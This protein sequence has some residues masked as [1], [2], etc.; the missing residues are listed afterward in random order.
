[1]PRRVSRR[2]Y[3]CDYDRATYL[4]RDGA[5]KLRDHAGKFD[6]TAS[7]FEEGAA[8]RVDPDGADTYDLK[9]V[10][11]DDNTTYAFSASSSTRPRKTS[12]T[13]GTGIRPFPITTTCAGIYQQLRVWPATGDQK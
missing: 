10:R 3:Y 8:H 6:D 4:L 2:S 11:L 7:L 5:G 9:I 13:F 12:T 1:M